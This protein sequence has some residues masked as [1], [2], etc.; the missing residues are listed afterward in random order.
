MTLNSSLAKEKYTQDMLDLI[1]AYTS[2]AGSL[3]VILVIVTLVR[4]EKK[5]RKTFYSTETGGQMNRRN[6]LN[7]EDDAVK[8]EMFTKNKAFWLPIRDDL[9]LWVN[10][11]WNRWLEEKPEWFTDEWKKFGEL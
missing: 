8:K 9:A 5:Y 2:W 3:L 11:G 1:M 7:S 6:F 4:M 10:R